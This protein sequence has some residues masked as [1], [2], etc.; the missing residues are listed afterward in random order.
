M[1]IVNRT[2][3]K[4]KEVYKDINLKLF[5]KHKSFYFFQNLI[6]LKRDKMVFNRL[7]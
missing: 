3:N 7:H 5:L 1:I 2:A 4:L 6:S